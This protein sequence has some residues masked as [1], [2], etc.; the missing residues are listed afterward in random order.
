V[1]GHG[2]NRGVLEPA[3]YELERTHGIRAC[4]VHP[5]SLSTVRVE[6]C[7]PEI[8]AAV[9]ETSVMLAIAPDDVKLS[10]L[11]DRYAP[12]ESQA[13]EVKQQVLDRGVTWPWS[14]GDQ[15]ITSDGVMG[16]DPRTATAELG[17][18]ILANALD[19]C[20]AVLERL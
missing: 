1:N 16:G 4:V 18:A 11:D 13:T 5:L 8:H 9:H 6:S 15:R 3:L 17:S 2:G 7:L 20:A 10:R 12:D 19:S 14:S